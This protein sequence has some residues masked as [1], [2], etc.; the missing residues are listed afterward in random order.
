MYVKPAEARRVPDPDTGGYL[1][2]E[3]KAVTSNASYWQRRVEDGD[4]ILSAAPAKPAKK[5]ED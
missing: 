4:C 2:P 1:L 3:G 5:K